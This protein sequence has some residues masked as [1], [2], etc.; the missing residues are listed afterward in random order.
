[1]LLPPRSQ[2]LLGPLCGIDLHLLVLFPHRSV[3]SW[4]HRPLLHL[5]CEGA[6]VLEHRWPVDGLLGSRCVAQCLPDPGRRLSSQV[7]LHRRRV[8]RCILWRG[9][10]SQPEAPV[11]SGLRAQGRL[12]N[13]VLVLLCRLDASPSQVKA[14]A[15][16]IPLRLALAWN[17]GSLRCR[18]QGPAPWRLLVALPTS[19]TRGRLLQEGVRLPWCGLVLLA[20]PSLSFLYCVFSAGYHLL[21]L[22]GI[23]HV[24]EALNLALDLV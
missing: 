3:S 8:E 10:R 5:C 12:Y 7:D 17:R 1:M 2:L 22:G 9:L 19:L 24:T 15:K 13:V 18:A 6:R 21:V 11:R 23:W 4:R 16:R 14:L 20:P